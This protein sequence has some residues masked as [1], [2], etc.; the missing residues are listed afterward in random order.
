MIILHCNFS[1]EGTNFGLDKFLGRGI[2]ER[3]GPTT[4][5]ERIWAKNSNFYMLDVV[6][7]PFLLFY[8]EIKNGHEVISSSAAAQMSDGDLLYDNRKLKFLVVVN[9]NET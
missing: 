6:L 1:K 5:K 4:H 3:E 7:D 8:F 9:D 2:I